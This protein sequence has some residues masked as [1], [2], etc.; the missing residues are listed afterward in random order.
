MKCYRLYTERKNMK[1]MAGMV[2]E[3]FGG[4]TI[5]KTIGYW[6]AKAEK[7]VVIEIITNE[8]VVTRRKIS[9]IVLKIRGYNQQE[10]VLVIET[11]VNEKTNFYI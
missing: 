11:D 9:Q 1:W 6:N 4:F 10:S 8:T 3:Y 7:A 5:Y 2:S